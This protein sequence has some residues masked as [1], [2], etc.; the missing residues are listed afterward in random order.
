MEAPTAWMLRI[1]Q[2]KFT[3]RRM[4]STLLKASAAVGA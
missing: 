4:C 1:S 2:P 3:S